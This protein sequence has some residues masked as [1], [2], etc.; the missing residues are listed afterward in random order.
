MLQ[1][2][3]L[4]SSRLCVLRGTVA[5]GLAEVPQSAEDIQVQLRSQLSQLHPH[6]TV[7][8]HHPLFPLQ[9]TELIIK[10]ISMD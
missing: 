4:D 1:C 10:K 8:P 2:V 6:N 9:N 7:T 5:E 3:H